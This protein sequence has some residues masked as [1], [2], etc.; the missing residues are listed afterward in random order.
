MEDGHCLKDHALAACKL[1][2][3]THFDVRVS[4]LTTIIQL[5]IGKMG[6]TLVPH[7]ALQPLT[8]AFSSLARLPLNQS[9]PHRELVIVIRPSYPRTESILHFRRLLSKSLVVHHRISDIRKGSYNSDSA[10][11]NSIKLSGDDAHKIT[12]KKDSSL[13]CLSGQKK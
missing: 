11:S 7:M 1:T 12:G 6:S 4:S 9:S 8:G 13:N 2:G 3:K 5:V 10:L